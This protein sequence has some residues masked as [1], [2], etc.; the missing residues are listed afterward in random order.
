MY[1]KYCI[2]NIRTQAQ[3][4]KLANYKLFDITS[5]NTQ[6]SNFWLALLSSFRETLL[7]NVKLSKK[8]INLF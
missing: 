5:A 6:L 7:Y 8:D 2:R 1:L 4:K 3:R